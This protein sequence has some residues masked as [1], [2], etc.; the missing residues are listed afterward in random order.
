[1]DED[2]KC[3]AEVQANIHGLESDEDLQAL[4]KVWIREA[5]RHRYS[6]NFTWL[7]RPIIQH[8]QDVVAM[9]EIVW[10]VK[11]DL[12]VET[13]IAHG[14]SLIFFASLLGLLGGG[15]VVLRVGHYIRPPKP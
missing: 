13:G 6:Y 10:Q 4:S 15:G 8:P 7:G 11:P 3:S 14:G 2:E 5:A 1:M 9:Q 12:I